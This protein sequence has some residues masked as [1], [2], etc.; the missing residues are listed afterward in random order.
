MYWATYFYNACGGMQVTASHNPIN[1]NGIKF[2]KKGS[3]PIDEED[4]LKMKSLVDRNLYGD[5]TSCGI[6]KDINRS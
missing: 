5:A 6:V 3:I 4:L 1:Y 2:I